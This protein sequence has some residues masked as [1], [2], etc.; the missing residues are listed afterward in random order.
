MVKTENFYKLGP[1]FCT[2]P[3]CYEGKPE[4]PDVI[5]RDKGKL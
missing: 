4:E 2:T 5:A 3:D 1:K